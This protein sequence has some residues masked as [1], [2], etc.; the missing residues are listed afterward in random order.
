[1]TNQKTAMFFAFYGLLLI[2]CAL[3]SFLTMGVKTQNILLLEGVTGVLALFFG[4][5]MNSH[6]SW[7]FIGGFIQSLLAL[8]L[9]GNQ[10]YL[11]FL[12]LLQ[13]TPISADITLEQQSLIFLLLSTTFIMTLYLIALQFGYSKA[14]L[15]ELQQLN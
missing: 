14:N 3:L 2:T 15:K 10:V 11:Q 8:I 13:K 9:I 6:K 7:A 1:M 5:F 4:H 12:R